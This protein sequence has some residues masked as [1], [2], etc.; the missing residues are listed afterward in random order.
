M[1]MVPMGVRYGVHGTL[2]IKEGA[3]VCQHGIESGRACAHRIPLAALQCLSEKRRA[4]LGGEPGGQRRLQSS[5]YGYFRPLFRSGGCDDI[6]RYWLQAQRLH[7]QLIHYTARDVRSALLFC[8][9]AQQRSASSSAVFAAR[10]LQHL[11]RYGVSLRHLTWQT[12]NGGEFK[13]DFPKVPA[14]SQHVR[15]PPA[16][17]TYRSDVETVHRIEEDEFFD[18]EDFASQASLHGIESEP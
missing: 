18:L 15:I 7:L 8:A 16:A 17:R 14:D 4:Q 6:P 3:G 10:I 13:G 12:D 11:D 9:F 2:R 5:R 1:V